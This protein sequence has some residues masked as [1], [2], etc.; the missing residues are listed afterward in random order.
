MPTL[1]RGSLVTI[2]LTAGQR[3]DVSAGGIVWQEGGSFTADFTQWAAILGAFTTTTTLTISAISADVVYEVMDEQE[4]R[5]SFVVVE[6][7]STA[8]PATGRTGVIYLTTEG[9][10]YWYEVNGAFLAFPGTPAVPANTTAP[11]I[12]GDS[13]VGDTLTV[14]N[15]G[16]WTNRPTSY[17]YQWTLD[18][19]DLEGETGTS[20]VIPE[21]AE[22]LDITCVVTAT[23]I[24]GDSDPEASNAV[25]VDA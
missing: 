17:A 2:E 21:G 22:E 25:T 5:S 8:L 9:A 12:S 23:N 7:D 18:G 19:S 20:L 10:Y 1:N 16:V 24:V 4:F 11:V 6:G 14:D 13:A 3:V 15:V